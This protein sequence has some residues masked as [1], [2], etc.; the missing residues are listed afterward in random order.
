[1]IYLCGPINGRSDADCI[2]W[3]QTA[4]TLLSSVGTRDP[5][6]RD[7]RGRELE[8]GIANQIVENDIADIKQCSGLLV[9]YDKPS[10]GTA[11]EVRMAKAEMRIPVYV[12]DISGKPLSPW[13]IFHADKI[14]VSLDEACAFI[15]AEALKS[16]VEIEKDRR[17]KMQ[18][19]LKTLVRETEERMAQFTK[20][21]I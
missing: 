5:M 15:L 4:K 20:T 17:R 18:K 11:M 2:D 7:Y 14:F 8:E 12:V 10:V 3:R 19:R 9:M 16:P 21:N 6:D 1:M 13:L